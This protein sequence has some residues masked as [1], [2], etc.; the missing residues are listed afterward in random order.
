[1]NPTQQTLALVKEAL[2][3]PNEA[4]RGD[5]AKGI[6]QATGLVAYDLQAP[7]LSMI[8]VITPLRNLIPR[9]KGSG[10][11]ATNWKAI[12]GINTTNVGL[13]VSEGNRGGAVTTVVTPY[14]AAYAGL[15]L[16]DFVTFE[17]D[18]AAQ[19][20]Q[21]AK[22]TAALNLLRSVMI[23]E[24]AILLGGNA[25]TA[26]GTTPTPTLAAGTTGGTIGASITVSVIAVAL[27]LD[28]LSRSTLAAGLPTAAIARTNTDGSSDSFGGGVA[29]KSAA[30]TQAV[31]AG[32][33][34][35]V[36]AI[37]AAV[38]GAV[39][40]AWY[41][42]T[43]GAERLFAITTINSCL[44][45]SLPGSSQLASALPSSDQSRNL[46]V[47]D[48]L[49]TYCANAGTNGAYRAVMPTGTAG[50][51]TGLTSDAAG[52]IV[53]IT[54]AFRYFWD[55]YRLSPDTIWVSAQELVNITK[56]VVGN[57]GAPLLR[58]TQ[59][60]TAQHSAI[61]GG[62]LLDAILNPIT[63]TMVKLRVHPNMPAGTLVFTTSS[64]PYPL[65]GVGNVMQVK[66]RRE[67]YQIDWPLRSR[68]NEIGV[69][70]DEVLQVY[71]TFSL[72][73]ITNIGNA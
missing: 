6:T 63:Q 29:Q 36:S 42:G 59:D 38:A 21:D 60:A 39:A 56:K 62:V 33:T 44:I 9:V 50:T 47:F 37:V 57:S 24:E 25:S 66:T 52:G 58:F 18:D 13:G 61:T 30:A 15:G 49:L 14:T 32:S 51:G 7:A 67:Y 53:E 11:T 34:N 2:G 69:Y 43:A 26:F 1:M 31:S 70:A 73:T 19:G 20:F 55:N 68:K 71:A 16:E 48:G 4:L 72:G 35:T 17:A 22:A 28:G 40:Y 41:A 10:G 12:T 3:A 23:G 8:P 45:T 5:L 64:I 65:S 54:T 46:L 27:T